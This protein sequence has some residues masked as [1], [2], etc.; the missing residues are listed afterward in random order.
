M[1]R[2]L[3]FEGVTSHLILKAKQL[4]DQIEKNIMSTLHK[5]RK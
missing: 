1:E 5:E 4:N 2:S 3:N